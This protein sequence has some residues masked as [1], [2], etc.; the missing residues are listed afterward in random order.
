MAPDTAARAILLLRA[1]SGI[2]DACTVDRQGLQ[3]VAAVE[4]RYGSTAL[5]PV[6][7][8]GLRVA[9]ERRVVLAVLKD[10]RFRGPPAPTVY[11]V[12]DLEGSG[13]EAGAAQETGLHTLVVGDRRFRI[14][15]EEILDSRTVYREKTMRLANSFVLFPERRSDPRTPSYF[16]VPPLG[17]QELEAAGEQLG[18]R[19]IMS[20]SPSAQA[21][22]LLRELCGFPADP[23]LATLLVAFDPRD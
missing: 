11:L 16:L 18:I 14:L 21:D 23:G 20:V 8:L 7:N 4:E 13:W 3:R 15:G 1:V 22:S 19:R 17:F 6:V 10:R 9:L 5:L 12:E 2:T